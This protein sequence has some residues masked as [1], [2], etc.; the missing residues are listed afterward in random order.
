[1]KKTTRKWLISLLIACSAVLLAMAGARLKLAES[2]ENQVQDILYRNFQ[3]ERHPEEAVIIA[4]DQNSLDYFQNNLKLLW[5]WPREMYAVATEFLAHCGAKLIAYDIIFAS[6]DIER[7]N[8][9]AEYSDLRF[10]RAMEQAGDVILAAQLEDSS[11]YDNESLVDSMKYSIYYDGPERLVRQY[12]GATLP[13]RLFQ[14]S[15]AMPGAVNYFAEDDGVCRKIPLLYRYENSLIA[16]MAFAATMLYT[17]EKGIVFDSLRHRLVVANR[18]IPVDRSG[19]FEIF[20]YGAGGPGQTFK[21][22]S[23]A[24]LIDSYLALQNGE[25][26]LI[27]KDT[28][29]D[30]AVFIGATA[31]GL[32]DLKTTPFSPIEPYPGVEIYATLFSNII[33]NEYIAHF[34]DSVWI[35]GA[36]FVLLLLGMC[37]QQL[38]ILKSSILS[39]LVFLAPLI[40]SVWLFQSQ[41]L[42]FP[43]VRSEI[44]LI[45]SVIAVLVL[46]YLTEGREKALVKKVFNRYLHPAVVENITREP[47]RIEMGGK[48]IEATVL[49]TDLQGFTGI[50]E[51]F[52]AHEIVQLLNDYFEKVENI[53]FRNNGM[54]DKYTGDGVMAIFGAPIE[55]GNHAMQTCRAVI[56]FQKLSKMSIE[57]AGKRVQLITRVGVNSGNLIVGNIGSK[58]RMD[59]TAIGDTVNLSAR[60]EGVNKLYG[61]QNIISEST[62]EYV[63]EQIACREIDYIR[64]KGRDKPLRIFSVIGDLELID[65]EIR[66]LLSIHSKALQKYRQ[67]EYSEAINIF[68]VLL[69]RK[70]DDAVAKVFIERCRQLIGNPE[71]IDEKGIFNI[72]V[73]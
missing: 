56:D 11:H 4:I 30:K 34:K 26:P 46:N 28:F 36:A 66:E 67:R 63:K 2:W 24:Q 58:N 39:L 5:P 42:I 41:L 19:N 14:E 51:L 50:S 57:K 18:S 37:W 21:Y 33:R 35:L 71:L 7:L 10:A 62:Y 32:L 40:G 17:G 73:K 12:P 69:K 70:P 3:V 15:M 1:M 64:V 38:S 55:S 44:A 52:T 59:Y 25:T 65:N 31:A 16:H 43:V 29:K 68:S 8:V 9:Q 48:E 13:I 54:L 23:F 27:P 6:P 60:L 20:W 45:L 49:F 47:G 53:I 22:V 61:T 72:T